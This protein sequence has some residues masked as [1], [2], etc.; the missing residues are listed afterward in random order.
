M[1]QGSP[2]PSGL[3]WL[4]NKSGRRKKFEIGS[5]QG[6]PSPFRA[7]LALIHDGLTNELEIACDTTQSEMKD[8]KSKSIASM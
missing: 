4:L 1:L 2:S 8:S 6:S 3:H 7:E 5:A